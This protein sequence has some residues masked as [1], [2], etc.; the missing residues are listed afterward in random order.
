MLN[1]RVYAYF[2]DCRIR[3]KK[4]KHIREVCLYRGSAV[5]IAVGAECNSKGR[6]STL[7]P[8]LRYTPNLREI[9]QLFD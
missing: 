1:T 5:F 7:Y 4:P 8:T 2:D 3:A 6:P 9:L